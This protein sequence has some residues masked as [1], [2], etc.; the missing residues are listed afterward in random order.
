M[1]WFWLTLLFHGCADYATIDEACPNKVVGGN[2]VSSEVAQEGLLRVGCYRQFLGMKPGEHNASLQ[3]VV[4]G[5]VGY[6][7]THAQPL[8]QIHLQVA[9]EDG[10]TGRDINERLDGV[11]LDLRSLEEGVE[12]EYWD[13]HALVGQGRIKP[14][15]DTWMDVP[16]IRGVLLHPGW[17][18]AG[19]EMVDYA[20]PSL[21]GPDVSMTY[22]NLVVAVD[23]PSPRGVPGPIVYPRDGQRGVPPSQR[24]EDPNDAYCGERLGYPMSVLVVVDGELDSTLDLVV[25]GAALHGPDGAVAL[26][27]RGGQDY[28]GDWAKISNHLVFLPLEPLQPQET[29]TLEA[30]IGW[31]TEE[32]QISVTFETG[33][34]L[35][36]EAFQLGDMCGGDP[37]TSAVGTD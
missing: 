11:A 6:V 25:E 37:I 28:G 10:F 7:E 1:K 2:Q 4:E 22:T 24:I 23:S 32:A 5:H 18:G 17:I 16:M 29:Y 13:I 20:L 35:L 33:K 31:G 9:D 3:E 30:A 12:R 27:Q 15:I 36:E 14:V 21:E 26:E 8:T 19:L 34:E